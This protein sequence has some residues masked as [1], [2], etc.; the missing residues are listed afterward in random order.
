MY[1]INDDEI[2]SKKIA[3][4]RKRIENNDARAYSGA[5]GR[6]FTC[7]VSA[8]LSVSTSVQL[9]ARVERHAGQAKVPPLF[10]FPLAL[11]CCI[12]QVSSYRSV[13]AQTFGRFFFG[14][15]A[16][17]VTVTFMPFSACSRIHQ[18]GNQSRGD[19]TACC[20]LRV[21]PNKIWLTYSANQ[22]Y[23]VIRDYRACLN[24]CIYGRLQGK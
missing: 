20:T 9:Q 12:L 4:T 21:A 7:R 18:S 6:G 16:L 10:A 3:A 8:G 23:A 2:L 1:V 17:L 5:G 24:G 15:I 22:S 13:R 11:R 14:V 19:C